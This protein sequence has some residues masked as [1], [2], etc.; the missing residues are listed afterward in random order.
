VIPAAH[1]YDARFRHESH[2]KTHFTTKP[3]IGWSDEGSAMVAD[4]KSGRLRE[5]SSYSNFAG[6][7]QADPATVG[8]IPGGGWRAEYRDD[9]GQS[10]SEPVLAWMVRGDGSCIPAAVDS[11]GFA[12]DP[13]DASNFVCLYHPDEKPPAQDPNE[14]S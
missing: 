2:G 4:H 1:P 12:D 9:D 7:A 3:V 8:V 13:T 14:A 11:T 5:A 6:I 10:V